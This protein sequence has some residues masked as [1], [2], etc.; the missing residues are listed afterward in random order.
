[1]ATEKQKRAARANIKKARAAW[2]KMSSRQHSLAQPEGRSRKKPG[3][4]GRG[5]FY[6][7]EVRPKN[8]FVSFRNQDV[9]KKGHLERLAGRRSSGSW[10][11]V[12]WLIGKDS[13]HIA[14]GR[15]VI[16]DPKAATMLKQIRGPII[17]VKGDIFK[18]YPR[19]NVPEK[20]KPT[21]AQKRA[22]ES[23]IRKAQAVRWKK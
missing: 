8:E 6:R 22:Q 11:T 14:N 9:G 1:M 15:L 16:N 17:H 18:A 10:D 3:S 2:R 19:R 7:V 20:E 5:S 12:S 13:A 4:T 23:N 21:T